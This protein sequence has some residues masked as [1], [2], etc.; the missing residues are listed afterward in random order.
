MTGPV[1]C[2]TLIAARITAARLKPLPRLG[3]EIAGQQPMKKIEDAGI[4]G[5]IMAA[6]LGHSPIDSAPVRD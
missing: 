2:W 6:R 5:E 4:D 1:Y 3:D